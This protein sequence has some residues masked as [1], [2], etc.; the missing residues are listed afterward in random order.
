MTIQIPDDLARGLEGIAAAQQ[1]SVEQLALDGLRS[2]VGGA[3]S[4]GAI[5]RALRKLPHPSVAAVDD[6]EAAIGAARLPV[7]DQGA[8]D[9]WPPE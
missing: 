1:K 9:R 7:R 2:L 4:P 8:F 6:L 3:G 5:L